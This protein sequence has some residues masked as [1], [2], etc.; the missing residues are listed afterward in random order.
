MDF[1]ITNMKT[2]G[3][4]QG[5]SFE[6]IIVCILCLCSSLIS[7]PNISWMYWILTHLSY[8]TTKVLEA[9]FMGCTRY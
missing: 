5:K 4:R 1:L 2:Q 6:G 9:K 3:A 8:R 7:T